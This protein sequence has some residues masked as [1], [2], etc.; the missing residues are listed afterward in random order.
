MWVVKLGGSLAG[1]NILSDWL[2]LLGR[3]GRGKVVVVPGGGAFA[4]AVR[5]AQR[6]HRFSDQTAHHLAILA[7]EQYALMLRDMCPAL[8]PARTVGSIHDVLGSDGLPVWMPSRMLADAR[9]V[10][11]SWNVTSDSLAAWL[12]KHLGADRLVL[13]KACEVPCNDI[14]IMAETGIVDAGFSDF[15]RG[16]DFESLVIN[17]GDLDVIEALLSGARCRGAMPLGAHG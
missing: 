14:N 1:S 7:M 2:A 12:A 8:I 4:E 16:A 10:P 15:V 5:A 3:H 9:G 6:I 17:R 13:V 11:E